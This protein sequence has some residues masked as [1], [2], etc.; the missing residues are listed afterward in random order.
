MSYYLHFKVAESIVLVELGAGRMQELIS[1]VSNFY[2]QC[3]KIVSI[4][5]I[6]KD[7]N[8]ISFMSGRV[9]ISHFANRQESKQQIFFQ[10]LSP[11]TVH[12][13]AIIV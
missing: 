1:P 11:Q 9:N 7:G 3:W 2:N 13:P 12:D 8:L 5:T 6:T 10:S 4:S